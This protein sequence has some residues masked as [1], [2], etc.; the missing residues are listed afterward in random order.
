VNHRAESRQSEHDDG[1]RAGR[2]E[3]REHKTWFLVYRVD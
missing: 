1:T 3:G 2:R